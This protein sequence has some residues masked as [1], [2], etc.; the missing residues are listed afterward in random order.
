MDLSRNTVSIYLYIVGS[1]VIKYLINEK[2]INRDDY[3]I[4]Y[5]KLSRL[6]IEELLGTENY[7]YKAIIN[8]PGIAYQLL[9]LKGL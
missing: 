3:V 7:G 6:K 1:H 4:E 2:E 5:Q 8:S 9:I